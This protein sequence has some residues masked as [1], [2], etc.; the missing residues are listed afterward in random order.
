[1]SNVLMRIN[2]RSQVLALQDAMNVIL[3]DDRTEG[4]F[5]VL[6]LLHG[7]GAN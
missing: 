7:G 5:P 6:W 1:M 4:E 2:F 3:P